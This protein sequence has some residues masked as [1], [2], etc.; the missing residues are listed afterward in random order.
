MNSEEIVKELANR[1][2]ADIEYFSGNLPER[3]A[4]AWHGYIAGLYEWKV[5]DIGFYKELIAL[6]PP[7]SEPNPIA[8]I[9]EG[10]DDEE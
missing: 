10:R 3:Y 8:E 9:F 7:I 1:I 5:Y 2:N 6:L 4:L